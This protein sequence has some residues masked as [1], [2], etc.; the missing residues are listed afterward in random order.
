MET[1]PT[2]PKTIHYCWFGG[3]KKPDVVTACIASWKKN[4][5]DFT[6]T[7]W[8][9]ETF[10]VTKHPFTA[11]MHSEKK[12]AF[13]SDYARLA[14]LEEHG[15]VYLD[16]DMELVQDIS[17]LLSAELLL[18]KE[19]DTV[20]SAGMIGATPRHPY[21]QACKEKYDNVH[22]LPPTIPR[23]ITDVYNKMKPS[24]LHV[25]VCEP[26]AFYPYSQETITLYN[27]SDVTPA[28]YGVHL[29][30]Y[31]WGHPVLRFL[32]KY[33]LYHTGKRILHTLGI[34][35]FLKKLLRLS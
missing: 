21:I 22:G 29:W 12:W 26:I 10:D 7:E 18:G 5:P 25:K 31:S 35:S 28:T 6:I 11:R 3:K 33:A 30:N 19:T 9:E 23:L 2:I 8:N 24:L 32:N 1:G 17:P 20:I 16:T 27:K 4:L 13:V 34:K 14:I 15:G